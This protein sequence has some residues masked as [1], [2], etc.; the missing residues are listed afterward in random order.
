[1]HNLRGII[2]S[3]SDVLA[4][5]GS[6]NPDLFFET[7]KLL[8][9]LLSK[10]IQPVLVSNTTWTVTIKDEGEKP[11]Q[12]YL[13]QF[14][15]S[16]L[17]YYQGG[18]DIDYKQYATAMQAILDKHGWTAPE[19]FYVGNTQEDVQ[20]ASNGGFPL[21]NA[22]WHGDNSPYGFEFASAKDVASFVDCCCLT[23]KDWFW[24]IE[25]GGL[26]IYSI[27]PFAEYSKAYPEGAIY[28]SDAKQAVK[29]DAGNIRFWGLLMAARIHLSG[30]GTEVDFV[31]PYP[32]HKPTSNKTKLMN[33]VAVVSGSLRARYLF[34]F[35]DRHTD[36][37]KS[38]TLRNN[39]KLPSANNQLST[40]K[41]NP[42]PTRTGPK[43]LKYKNK[44][45]IKDK[46]VL[47]VDDICTEGYSLEASR[48]FFEAAG[49]NVILLSWLK[50]P[51]RNDYHAIDEITPAIKRPFSKFSPTRVHEKIYSNSENVINSN[52]DTEIA[53]AYK[54]YVSWDWPA[55]LI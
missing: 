3:L 54:K 23:P 34:D 28:S 37:E 9:F 38:Q 4:H 44:P 5:K 39:G 46:T 45:N 31:A 30:I 16:Q 2:F 1:M 22:K 6:I 48:A 17:P 52:A 40:I 20:A 50:T 11:F 12:E 41:L 27:A 53:E 47:V 25:D 7:V 18:R 21:L 43:Q 29:Q 42:T 36:A 51:G 49:A 10:G 15:G 32:G 33:A 19:V 13:S 24:G 55:G 35:I 14:V 26:R 8:K